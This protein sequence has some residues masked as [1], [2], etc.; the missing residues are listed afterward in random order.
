MQAV[1]T[2]KPGLLPATGWLYRQV[3]I[4]PLIAFRIMFGF[5]LMLH[6]VS[7]IANGT[8]YQH[9]V[10]PP[11]TFTFIGFEFLQSLAGP[12]MYWYVAVMAI[13]A[14]L[15]MIG[16]WYRFAMFAYAL[17]WTLLYLMQ[18]AGYNNH[19][20]LVLL[21]CW[22]MAFLPAN[23]YFSADVKRGAVRE[24]ATCPWYCIGIFI[25][26]VSVMYFFAAMSKITPDWFSGKFIAIQFS[27][28]SQH[29][30]LGII[31]GNEWF[32]WFICYAGFLF[33]LLI[34]P[35]LLIK[36]TR[37]FAFIISCC[38]HLF[39]SYTFKLGIFPYLSIALTIFFFDAYQVNRI[40]FRKKPIIPSIA[41]GFDMKPAMAK[42]VTGCLFLYMLF[43]L[44]LPVRYLMF[45]GNVFWTEEGYRMS[46][47]MMLR[48]KSGNL[49]Y[50]V[51]DPVSKK[52]WKIEPSRIFSLSHMR[53]LSTSPD[54]I[55]QYAQYI[56]KGFEKKGY[57]GVQVFAIGSVSLNRNPARPMVDPG[58]DLAST[59]W[60]PFRHSGWITAY[61]E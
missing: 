60:E 38:F 13:L 5:L 30:L 59:K 23:R 50:K 49:F 1:I 53:T 17:M 26:Q 4:A 32:Q 46:W 40:F 36:K 41:N 29:P 42:L 47:K 14:A 18:K 10:S 35:L 56:K 15:V 16:A 24:S 25:F 31:Y 20:Y 45:P 12:G 37:Y 11:F 3:N 44:L 9:Y 54:I 8:V 52:S 21:L 22:I 55:W 2:N 28:L 33:D 43:Q 61:P 39:N 51:Y 6:S 34:V 48:T 58:A 7:T 27:R 19:Y 57:Q